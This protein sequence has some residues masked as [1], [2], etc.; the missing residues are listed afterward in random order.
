[1]AVHFKRE[2][3]DMMLSVGRATLNSFKRAINTYST[4]ADQLRN[5][6]EGSEE[7]LC[8]KVYLLKN[9]T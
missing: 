4:Q 1:M 8:Y 2:K 7:M 5:L 9:L 6:C 3:K